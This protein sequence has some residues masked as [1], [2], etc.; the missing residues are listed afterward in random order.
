MR[1]LVPTLVFS[2]VLSFAAFGAAIAGGNVNFVAGSRGLG[3]DLWGE[4]DQQ[5]VFGL[6]ADYAGQAWPVRVEGAIFVSSGTGD[7]IEPVFSSRA[8]VEN[9]ISELAFG[10]NHTWDTRGR[11]R[12]FLGGGLAWLV[13]ESDIR[14]EFFE[15]Q[16]DDS[17]GLG[18]YAHGGVFWRIGA[19]FNLGVDLRLMGT[20][21]LGLFGQNGDAGYGQLG[22][23]F[24]FGW[25]PYP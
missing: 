12:P 13:A 19:T 5:H 16:H 10:L 6:V 8:E 1:R 11:T 3:S 18:V 24:G 23:V 15:D 2:S 7:F 14:S 25:P 9:R 20:T 22:F 4:T 21:E 17:E